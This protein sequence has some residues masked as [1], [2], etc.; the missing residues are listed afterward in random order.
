M[1]Y[2]SFSLNGNWD[3]DYSPDSYSSDI[4]PE[5][6]GEN[7]SDALPSY[8]EDMTEKFQSASFFRKLRINPEYGIQSYPIS[9]TAPDM[10]LANIVGCFFY[11]RKFICTEELKNCTIY[12][13]GVMNT[14][15]VW[16]NNTF[17]G[18]HEGYSAPFE[19]AIPDCL[20]I[21]GENTIVLSVSNHYLKGYKDRIVSGLT[22]RAANE[23]SGGIMGNAEIRVYNSPLRN[24]SVSVASSCNRVFVKA[25]LTDVA[26]LKWQ[27]LDGQDCVMEG[28]G[29]GSFDFDAK[30]LKL[31]SPEEPNLYTLRV[32]CE[33]YCIDRAF[34]RRVLTTDKTAVMLNS[35]P[36]Y[37][38]GVCE[39]C[40][41]PETIHLHHDYTYY[42]KM[43]KCFKKLGFNFIRF[44]TYV[45]CEEYLKATDE[46]G[47]LVHI[48][49]PNNTTLKQWM[50][51]VDFASTHP[52]VVIYCCGNELLIDDDF[53]QHLREC[54]DYV[55]QNTDSLFS[56][57]SALRGLEYCIESTQSENTLSEPFV[58]HPK[59]FETMAEFC[60]IYNSYTLGQNSYM[61]LDCKS[62]EI[63]SWSSVYKKP[64][65]SHEICIDGTFTDLSLMS[66]YD[67]S[68]VGETKMFSSIKKHLEDKGILSRASLYFNNSSRWQQ[69]VR[70][71]CF[72][73]VRMSQGLSG[74]DFLGPIDTH[75]HTFG[76]DVGMMNEFYELKPGETIRN[77]GMYNSPTVL[78][79]NL[80]RKTNFYSGEDMSFALYVSHYG[81]RELCGAALTVRLMMDGNIV[82]EEF[83]SI[84]TIAQGA[85]SKLCDLNYKLPV[86]AKP[87]EL[88]LC[89]SLSEGEIF[90]QNEWELYVFPILSANADGI[91][92]S[93]GMKYDEL[94]RRLSNGETVLI[95]GT[96]PFK[97]LPTTFRI[98]LAGRCSGNLATV[99]EEH[100]VFYDI[101]NDGFCSWQ[102]GELLEG[103][104]A[105]VMESDLVPFEP[106]VEVVSSHK[107]IIRQGALFE[108]GALS[109]KL[110]VCSFNFKSD[111]PCAQYLKS[112][113]IEYAKSTDFCPKHN[114]TE[115]MLF[116]MVNTKI[117]EAEGN[118]NFAFNPND[119]TA[120]KG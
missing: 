31:W 94:R 20:I 76:Y 98:S 59:R 114:L 109:G 67:S 24:I 103:G 111:D 95:F 102:F 9:D 87:C 45:P 112:A 52:S 99:I 8:W 92:V 29:N 86:V 7:I 96:E 108:F 36:Y 104:N 13:E 74:Y 41:Y 106:I 90:A 17:I 72:E 43:V 101:P 100:P 64:R 11:R 110:M 51:I 12:F 71:Y 73:S 119:K 97:A 34:A 66:R 10:A 42:R 46:L 113:L 15:S 44:H 60:D 32:S 118:T 91:T 1:L 84:D 14:V 49:S 40:Y 117:K 68:R 27:V 25:N 23:Y 115:E 120:M 26:E 89:V 19:L 47:M 30:A 61:S 2:T 5:F 75:W 21:E 6:R 28:I 65:L 57:M 81:L 38:R 4:V 22:S 53:I 93:E 80:K 56:P 79:N 82:R 62:E 69:K 16:I 39:H 116:S 85:V 58:H 18:R 48:E 35:K 54:A 107:Y 83:I 33:G 50:E 3:M 70:K 105:V 77:V 63:D 37:L 78:L 88:K 55:H